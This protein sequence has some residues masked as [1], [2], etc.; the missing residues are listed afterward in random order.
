M[1][2]F[3]NVIALIVST[4]IFLIFWLND[5]IQITQEVLDLFPQTSDKQVI[6]IY[7]QFSNSKHIFVAV[8]G[9][10]RDSLNSLN[11]FLNE[12]GKLDNVAN[13]LTRTKLSEALG[14]FIDENYLYTAQPVYTGHVLQR[15]DIESR[16]ISGLQSLQ[17]VMF[18]DDMLDKNLEDMIDSNSALHLDSKASSKRLLDRSDIDTDSGVATK[19]H[20]T[21]NNIKSNSTFDAKTRVFHPHDPL[22]RGGR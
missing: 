16:I 1:R 13:V 2:R 20:F 18:Q 5:K 6:D 19:E 22:S 21:L 4:G 12:V 7:R 10:S 8:R 3:A 14:A 9:F 17:K 15:K 11:G